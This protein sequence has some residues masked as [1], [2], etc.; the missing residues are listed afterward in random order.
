MATKLSDSDVEIIHRTCRSAYY[1]G[2]FHFVFTCIF[3]ARLW[4]DLTSPNLVLVCKDPT[5][6][7]FKDDCRL[8]AVLYWT[9]EERSRFLCFVWWLQN[10]V[11]F[12]S[13]WSTYIWIARTSESI[14][15][16]VSEYKLCVF[17]LMAGAGVLFWKAY[18]LTMY[19]SPVMDWCPG[20]SSSTQSTWLIVPTIAVRSCPEGGALVVQRK[21]GEK[22]L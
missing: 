5:Y 6:S 19:S 3:C 21:G 4:S 7:I 15:K 1:R 16:L 14:Y 22:F 2:C 12:T 20:D 10:Y 13:L 11:G 9:H 17:F 18:R 8:T